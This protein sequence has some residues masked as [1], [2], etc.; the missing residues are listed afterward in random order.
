[1]R[2]TF[3]AV[4]I[5]LLV[6]C[7]S[8]CATVLGIDQPK[9]RDDTAIDSTNVGTSCTAHCADAPPPGWD[10]PFASIETTAAAPPACDGD[11]PHAAFDGSSSLVAPPAACTCE[12]GAPTGVACSAPVINLFDDNTCTSSCGTKDQP[13]VAKPGCAVLNVGGCGG[14]HAILGASTATGGSCAPSS[15]ATVAPASWSTV[16]R[17]CGATAPPDTS[18]CGAGRVCVPRPALP[19]RPDVLCIASPGDVACPAGYPTRTVAYAAFQDTR[20]CSACTCGAPTGASC[21]TVAATSYGDFA[22]TMGPKPMTAPSSCIDMGG[23]SASFTAP[24]ASGGSC[25][26]D[27]GAPIGDATPTSPTTICCS[28]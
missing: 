15:T 8:S 13:L 17:L 20:A 19:A 1:M 14:T 4:A 26:K 2:A 6:P 9:D 22:C 7:A 12:C 11:F 28:A 23:R 21:G 27:G 25:A 10:G 18:S 24:V 16:H 3:S 5:C